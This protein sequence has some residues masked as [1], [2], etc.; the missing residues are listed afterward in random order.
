MCSSGLGW[1]SQAPKPE[2]LVLPICESCDKE[3]GGWQASTMCQATQGRENR[4]KVECCPYPIRE[5]PIPSLDL[6][7]PL[8]EA[9]IPLLLICV[10]RVRMYFSGSN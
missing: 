3:V 7:G 6:P 8:A 1:V 10:V 2:T 5:G 4:Q 9:H